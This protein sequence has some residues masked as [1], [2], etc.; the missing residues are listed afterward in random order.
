MANLIAKSTGMS[1]S[2]LLKGDF[3]LS[4]Q[5]MVEITPTWTKEP[6]LVHTES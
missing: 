3:P 4:E 5:I 1:K 2:R 6:M